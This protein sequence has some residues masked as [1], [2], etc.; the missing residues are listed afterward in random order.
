[1]EVS[2]KV[3]GVTSK[4]VG[5]SNFQLHRIGI[6]AGGYCSKHLHKH[7][8]NG[9]FV[10]SGELLIKVWKPYGLT[11]LTTLVFGDYTSVP[12]NQYHMFRAIKDTVCYE[13]YYSENVSDSDIS[14]ETIGG[15][16][17]A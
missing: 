8:H 4:I 13:I 15:V 7:R 9:F 2:G 12:P 14:R 11:D 10:E 6:E 17:H 16:N 3:W 1:M 5:N